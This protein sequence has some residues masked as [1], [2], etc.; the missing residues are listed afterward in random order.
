LIHRAWPPVHADRQRP[1]AAG[2]LGQFHNTLEYGV[3]WERNRQPTI[4]VLADVQAC[5]AST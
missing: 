2:A 1:G 4:T 5:R 3:I